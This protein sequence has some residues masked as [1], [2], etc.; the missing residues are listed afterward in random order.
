MLDKLMATWSCEN[1]SDFSDAMFYESKFFAGDIRILTYT[2]IGIEYELRIRLHLK[3]VN[4]KF[5]K[6]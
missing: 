1:L 5:V 6:V 4:T 3:Q 2:D